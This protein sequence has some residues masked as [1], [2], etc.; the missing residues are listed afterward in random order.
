MNIREK[1]QQISDLK[2]DIDKYFDGNI[3]YDLVDL[4]DQYWTVFN[5]R[6]LESDHDNQYT[7]ANDVGWSENNP[8][9]IEGPDREHLYQ[10]E[11]RCVLRK[12]EFTLVC[13][14]SNSGT[15]E[16]LVFDNS[17][18]IPERKLSQ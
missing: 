13:I 5:E 7:R 18:E 15:I 1:L 10:E 4:T 11:V 17:K 14:R 12:G 8:M 16:D 2:A 6:K 9:D 3:Y